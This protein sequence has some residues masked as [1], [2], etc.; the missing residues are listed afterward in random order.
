MHQISCAI[1]FKTYW[2]EKK[3]KKALE[4]NES[5]RSRILFLGTAEQARVYVT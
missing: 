1:E 3:T 4:Q 5:S 2:V